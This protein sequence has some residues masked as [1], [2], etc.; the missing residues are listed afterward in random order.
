MNIFTILM[1]K[2]ISFIVMCIT[3]ACLLGLFMNQLRDAPLPL[4]YETKEARLTRSIERLAVEQRQVTATV[5]S[6]EISPSLSLRDFES[7]V[8]ARN[9]L[10]LDARPEIFYRFGHVPGAVSFPREAFEHA[11]ERLKPRLEKDRNQPLVVYCSSA[12]CEDAGLVRAAFQKLGY[13]NV[14]V[15]HGGWSEWTVASLPEEKS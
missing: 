9:V 15:F 1:R 12:S 2:D 13:Q 14:G 11:Y 8:F 3:V 6:A 10:I 5:S 7:L 4:I